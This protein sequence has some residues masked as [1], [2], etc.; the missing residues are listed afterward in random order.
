MKKLMFAAVAIAAGI[1]VADV[2]S[3]NTVGYLNPANFRTSYTL[4]GPMFGDVGTQDEGSFTIDIQNIV[5]VG[6]NIPDGSSTANTISIQKLNATG[7][8]VSGTMLYWTNCNRKKGMSGTVFCHGWYPATGTTPGSMSLVAGESLWTYF[9]EGVDCSLQ[10]S[11]EVAS[12]EVYKPLGQSYNAICNP[13]PVTVDIQNVAPAALDPADVPDGSSTAQTIS[14]QKLTATGG[15]VSGSMLYWTN[16]NR[17]KGMSGTVFCHGWY[18]AT[19]TTPGSMTLTAGEGLW[20]YSPNNK[21]SLVFPSAFATK[22]D[23]TE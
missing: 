22:D 20:A 12:G 6:D 5:P 15:T 19:G 8:T 23:V 16:C 9:P 11:G 7:G 17:K 13:I 3:A 14:V 4:F 10:F 1:A 2:T 21:C 18:P